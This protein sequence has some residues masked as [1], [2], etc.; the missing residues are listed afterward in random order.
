M[1]KQEGVGVGPINGVYVRADLERAFRAAMKLDHF[2][3]HVTM[4]RI[5]PEQPESRGSCTPPRW[6][7]QR[8]LPRRGSCVVWWTRLAT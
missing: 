5:A 6:I 3:Q 8:P 1:R 7:A 2:E 4:V